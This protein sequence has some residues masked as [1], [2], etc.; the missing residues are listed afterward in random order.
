M[1]RYKKAVWDELYGMILIW[2]T[3]IDNPKN[4]GETI[5]RLRLR[6]IQLCAIL[7]K[8]EELATHV[9]QARR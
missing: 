9:P 4:T 1:E 2:D 6:I 7:D 3:T 5:S 8:I